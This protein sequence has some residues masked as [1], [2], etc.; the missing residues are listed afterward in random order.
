[1]KFKTVINGTKVTISSDLLEKYNRP[2]PRY[3]SYPTAPVW[4][5]DFGPE[6]YKSALCST[7]AP[8]HQRTNA[9]SLY[10]HIPFCKKR[11]HFCGCSTIATNQNDAADQYIDAVGREISLVKDHLQAKGV[12]QLHYGGGT[13]TFLSPRQLEKLWEHIS[14]H[15]TIGEDA[16][17]GI[18]VDPRV[19]SVEQLK[20]LRRQGFNRISLGVQD[21]SKNVQEAIGRVQAFEEISE[22]I[23]NA[24]GLGFKSVN[25]DLVYGL[26]HQTEKSFKDTVKKI[27]KLSPDR[28][29]CFNFAYVP[30]MMPHQKHIDEKM[31][32]SSNTK[33]AIF[34]KTIEQLGK[35]GYDFIGMDHFAKSTDEL[36]IAAKN[37]SLWRNFQ[38]YSAGVRPENGSDPALIGFGLTSI[39]DAGG[40]YAQN[41]KKLIDYYKSIEGGSLATVKGWKLSKNDLERRK[42]IR[43]LFCK[44]EAL[45]T[46]DW[47]LETGDLEKNKLIKT[48]K[49]I[50]KITALGRLFVRNIAMV[51]DE[52]L[53]EGEQKFSK[54]V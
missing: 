50:L 35:A 37:G 7:N 4:T 14:K 24:R 43:E 12:V 23:D 34:C 28:V 19:T 16:E 36:S 22:L 8:T 3:T 39:S 52:Y 51:F 38:G 29:A 6:D 9:L 44:E 47:R 17:I 49:N 33:F 11:C 25:V 32:P 18:E 2:G 46:G 41:E 30:W 21:F 15:F 1:M 13:P 26:P 42:L 54:T 45:L 10:F 31:L 27:I 40:C 5:T 20:T 53:K 48:E